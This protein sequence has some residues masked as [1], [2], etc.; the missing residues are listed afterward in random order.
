VR[1]STDSGTVRYRLLKHEFKESSVIGETV[2]PRN[3]VFGNGVE[4]GQSR[5]RLVIERVWRL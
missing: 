4:T 5:E 1:Y 2:R 3:L